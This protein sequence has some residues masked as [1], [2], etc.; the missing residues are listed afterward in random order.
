MGNFPKLDNLFFAVCSTAIKN[1]SWKYADFEKVKVV[2]GQLLALKNY[3]D[4]LPTE[5]PKETPKEE[6]GVAIEM[7]NQEKKNS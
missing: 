3:V 6:V 4:S 2:E 1:T 7:P 5:A